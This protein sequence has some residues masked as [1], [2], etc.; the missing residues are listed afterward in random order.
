MPYSVQHNCKSKSVE[1]ILVLFFL[2]YHLLGEQGDRG[3]LM[4]SADTAILK[5]ILAYCLRV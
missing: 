3:Q 1:R 5:N 2:L 4:A